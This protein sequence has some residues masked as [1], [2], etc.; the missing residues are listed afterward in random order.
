MCVCLSQAPQQQQQEAVQ[1]LRQ[2]YRPHIHEGEPPLQLSVR[3]PLLLRTVSPHLLILY[4]ETDPLALTP[5]NEDSLV[6]RTPGSPLRDIVTRLF[7]YDLFWQR[8]PPG[9]NKNF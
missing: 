4:S 9:P 1:P 8:A 2:L 3:Q 5:V 6:E 7:T